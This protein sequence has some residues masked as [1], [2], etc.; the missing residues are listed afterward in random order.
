MLASWYRKYAKQGLA[1]IGITEMSPT[2][3]DVK[4]TA[5]ERDLSYPIVIDSGERIFKKYGL[6]SH[7]TT[8]VINRT[9][10]IAR[11]EV[12]FVRGDEK[13]IEASILPLLRSRM[14]KRGGGR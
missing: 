10:K 8:I 14:S 9:G 5:R 1:V 2:L 7:P 11:V 13:Q 12:G 3:A 4:K 6:E